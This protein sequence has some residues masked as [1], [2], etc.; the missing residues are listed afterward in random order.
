M[1]KIA[2]CDYSVL[3]HLRKDLNLFLTVSE[4]SEGVNVTRGIVCRI[5]TNHLALGT[6]SC[7]M[8]AFITVLF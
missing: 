4:C 7:A 2:F 3:Y 1:L 5:R 6:V 8:S